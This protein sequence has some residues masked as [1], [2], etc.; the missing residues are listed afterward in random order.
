MPEWLKEHRELQYLRSVAS[1]T[2]RPRRRK[3]KR[4]KVPRSY[5]TERYD[6]IREDKESA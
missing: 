1:V 5:V 2:N 6:K 3:K 4:A